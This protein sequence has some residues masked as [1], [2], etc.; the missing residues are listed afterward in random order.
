MFSISSITIYYGTQSDIRVKRYYG[1]NLLGATIFNY[2]GL[3][4]LRDSIKNP[5][6]KLFSFEFHGSSNFNFERLDILRDSTGYLSK[7]ILLSE[8]SSIFRF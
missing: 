2:E 7:K 1:F 8:L 5:S 6:K 4:I 3:D